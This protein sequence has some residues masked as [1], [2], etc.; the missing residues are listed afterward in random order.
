MVT[1][2]VL[3]GD[4]GGADAQA[5]RTSTPSKNNNFMEFNGKI[6]KNN[7]NNI[8]NDS[9][10]SHSNTRFKNPQWKIP[11]LKSTSLSPACY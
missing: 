9:R 1:S 4:C 3:I 11:C 7:Y 5:E 6:F 2:G 10:L 8:K